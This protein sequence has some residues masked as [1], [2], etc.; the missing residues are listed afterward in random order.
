MADILVKEFTYKTSTQGETFF[1]QIFGDGTFIRRNGYTV[2]E[3]TEQVF[4]DKLKKSINTNGVSSP[5][6]THYILSS[7][8]KEASIS[9]V[10]DEWSK[11]N[12]DKSS[13]LAFGEASNADSSFAKNLAKNNAI[14]QFKKKQ[15]TSNITINGA[16]I[17]QDKLYTN[18]DRTYSS[19]LVVQVDAF[20]PEKAVTEQN[21]GGNSATLDDENRT[22]ITGI[23]E[24][25]PEIE[26]A[27]KYQSKVAISAKAIKN[28]RTYLKGGYTFSNTTTE[29]QQ[30][31]LWDNL[32]AEVAA[33]IY[34]SD[35]EIIS[36]LDEQ[37]NGVGYKIKQKSF[38]IT[39]VAADRPKEQL[40]QTPPPPTQ[41]PAP[42]PKSVK[43]DPVIYQPKTRVSK[44]KSTKGGEYT[45]KIS[46]KDYKGPYIKAYKNKYYAGSNLDQNGVEL[47]PV[48]TE[49]SNI[50][51]PALALLFSAIQGFFK[52]TASNADR[53]KGVTKR[54]FIQTK[55]DNKIVEVDK[56]NYQQ[57][58]LAL[59]N[60][61]FATVD[62]II[63]GPAEDKNFNGYPFEGAE[64]KNKKA[65]LALE[66]QM[67]GIST[68]IK[69]YKYLV[70]DPAIYQKP[71]L[72]S[73]VIVVKDLQTDIENSRK[74]NFDYKR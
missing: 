63:K 48:G 38:K 9:Q 68:L 45:E 10:R 61:N 2:V 73:Q 53:E 39:T 17:T 72:T 13:N 28:G 16:V 44:P 62:W 54:Y 74:A 8:S 47:I 3:P 36:G 60:Q 30:N 31:E 6:G 71:E 58:Q 14:D 64:S 20:I 27:D 51:T 65:I 12:D 21:T 18:P 5:D 15:S 4:L 49:G 66:K 25:L 19:L 57:A 41:E 23:T 37:R 69:D 33:D 43:K 56:S 70:E 11:Y 34:A 40:K 1:V 29:Q 32:Y 24:E 35:V 26:M 55:K 22:V 59:P 50:I 42:P 67:P 7:L 52:K 46:G